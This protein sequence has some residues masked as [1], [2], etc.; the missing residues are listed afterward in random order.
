MNI[1]ER[2]C[3]LVE[4]LYGVE[5]QVE[6]IAWGGYA[7]SHKSQIVVNRN[8]EDVAFFLSVLFHEAGHV[9]CF[10]N[11]IYPA[12]HGIWGISM[13]SKKEKRAVV[14]TGWK[15]EQYVDRWAEKE[16]KKHFP[17][18]KFI[19]T[20]KGED[21]RKWLHDNHLYKWKQ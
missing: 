19:G 12:Y 15:A 7:R 11:R 14:L 3:R 17:K 1:K 8:E 5:V 2:A 18:Y 20:Y 10:R 4:K 16:M 21:D 9:H 6:D 13:L